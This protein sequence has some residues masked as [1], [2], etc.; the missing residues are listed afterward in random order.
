[1]ADAGKIP[2][3]TS[4]TTDSKMDLTTEDEALIIEPTSPVPGYPGTTIPPLRSVSGYGIHYN[5][6]PEEIKSFKYLRYIL[7]S[8][9]AKLFDVPAETPQVTPVVLP[10]WWIFENVPDVN[11]QEIGRL[12]GSGHSYTY[13]EILQQGLTIQYGEADELRRN[14]NH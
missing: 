5:Y 12:I 1:M 7:V 3:N 14:A 10:L 8:D 4:N 6:F 13:P 9:A 2:S 11:I